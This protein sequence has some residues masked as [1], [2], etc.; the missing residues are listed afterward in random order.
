MSF[1][2]NRRII[3]MTLTK[4]GFL[5]D[6]MGQDCH[7]YQQYREL[8]QNAI[9]AILKTPEKTG[10]I[11][12]EEDEAFPG[13]L[14]IID[15]G[16]GMIPKEL[17]DYLNDLSSSSS[18]QRL[19]GNYGSGAKI[20][21]LSRNH[22][23]LLYCSWQ[24]GKGYMILIG[25]HADGQ[26]GCFD[27]GMEDEGTVHVR[28]LIDDEYKPKY[29]KDH[30]TKVI[31]CGLEDD[32][33]T[34]FPGGD[35]PTERWLP[36]YLARRYFRI[37]EGI[38]LYA[39]EGWRTE[40][41]QRRRVLGQQA[42]L[43]DFSVQQGTLQLTQAKAHW[44]IMKEDAAGSGQGRLNLL[45][46]HA[47]VLY[48]NE[49]YEANDH[50]R[51]DN[52]RLQKF[53]ITF[54]Y[55]R[56][57]IYVEPQ[58]SKLTTDLARSRVFVSGEN[59]PTPWD[60]WAQEFRENLPAPIREMIIKEGQDRDPKSYEDSIQRRLDKVR[61]LYPPGRYVPAETGPKK[62]VV[63]IPDLKL[64]PVIITCPGLGSSG[65]G[66]NGDSIRKGGTKGGV[67][68]LL[69]KNR[70]KR[71]IKPIEAHRYP[72]VVWLSITDP[73]S[74]RSPEDLEDRAARYVH[75]TN[76]LYINADFRGLTEF[77]D[78]CIQEMAHSEEEA[79]VVKATVEQ[80]YQ[81][82]LV[83]A[84]VSA[85]Y[86]L[87][88]KVWTIANFEGSISEEA[89]SGRAMERYHIWNAVK[90]DVSTRLGT[91]KEEKKRGRSRKVVRVK[92]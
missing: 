35:K 10:Q 75:S 18:T 6:R 51:A 29:I 81:Q 90:R 21:A 53:G 71:P 59:F 67:L 45:R 26:Y 86:L 31:L 88:S 24:N 78:Q 30:G 73:K 54:G 87:N 27:L 19:D 42:A 85:Q 15:T 43:N 50:I 7:P 2:S 64:G 79:N 33:E 76:Y 47:A 16:I 22:K 12:W 69:T 38:N 49:I 70:S 56:V 1:N 40:H 46:G 84:V 8:T 41:N 20:S 36:Q 80:Y 57:V 5:V 58:G 60:D 55:G 23:G 68:G 83:E 77:V 92:G 44:W 39:R 65:K 9:E 74:P 48:Q 11:I 61:H 91:K 14:A 89:L 62:E 52:A 82:G 66:G 3:P 34:I 28:E 72:E 63:P 4:N 37:P 13:K 32:A 17:R 25:R